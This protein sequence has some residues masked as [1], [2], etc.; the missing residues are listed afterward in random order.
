MNALT[1]SIVSVVAGAALAAVAIFM[2]V[3]ALTPS[4]KQSEAPLIVY[5][6]TN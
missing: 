3:T 1:T 2:G 4:A 6:D 5:G